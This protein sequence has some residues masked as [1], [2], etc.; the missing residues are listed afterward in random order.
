VELR[1]SDC[2]RRRL[3][4]YRVGEGRL[5][6]LLRDR[7]GIDA[8]LVRVNVGSRLQRVGTTPT[9]AELADKTWTIWQLLSSAAVI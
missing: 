8:K 3:N 5:R 9:V 1:I 4:S 6:C 7:R 2:L